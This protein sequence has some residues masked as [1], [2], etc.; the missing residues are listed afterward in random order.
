VLNKL[1]LLAKRRVSIGTAS[2][3]SMCSLVFFAHTQAINVE[4]E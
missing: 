1:C 4:V 3:Q 2:S